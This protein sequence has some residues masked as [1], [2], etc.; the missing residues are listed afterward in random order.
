VKDNIAVAI[1]SALLRSMIDLVEV[2]FGQSNPIFLKDIPD[3]F[4]GSF[5]REATATH[6]LGRGNNIDWR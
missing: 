1:R 3:L 4:S 5:I 6:D 2:D